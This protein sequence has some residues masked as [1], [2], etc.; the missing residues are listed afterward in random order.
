MTSKRT[1][2][3]P[4][5]LCIITLFFHWT[6]CAQN[7]DSK[8]QSQEVA[9]PGLSNDQIAQFVRK[10]LNVPGNISIDVKDGESS[11]PGLKEILI[12]FR[13]DRVNQNQQA[14]ITP[15]KQLIVGRTFD[16]TIDPYQKNWEKISFDK[17][18]EKGSPDA[19]VVIV[20]YSDFQ[21]PY[22]SRAHITVS[23]LLKEYEG[24][25][26][27]VYKHLP[28]GM[29]NWAEDAAVASACVQT[30]NNDAF[31]KLSDVLFENQKTITKETLSEKVLEVAGE[32]N[33]NAEELQ[34][35]MKDRTTMP[36]VQ[37]NIA[38]AGSLGFNSTPSFVI[39]GRPVV[40]ALQLEQ[41]KQII[42]EELATP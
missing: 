20:E 29:H 17:V 40:G 41:F 36:L 31:W 21:C 12:Q 26:K 7:S 35:C 5:L 34:K 25:V 14:W 32:S 18:P 42:D 1:S 9:A 23:E 33:L 19:K 3:L 13:S 16:M 38:E 6:A 2:V 4:T 24:K 8:K 28:L 39:N 27:L 37:Q 30:Q 11:V 10:A 22:C 15:N